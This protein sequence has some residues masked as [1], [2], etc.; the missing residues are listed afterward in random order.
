MSSIFFFYKL[1]FY[2]I[3]WIKIS[4]FISVF[5]LT[6]SASIYRSPEV[7]PF[8]VHE[9]ILFEEFKKKVKI[10]RNGLFNTTCCNTTN[11]IV[12]NVSHSLWPT[13]VYLIL[14]CFSL[15]SYLSTGIN[16]ELPY[17]F[18]STFISIWEASCLIWNL[19]R[20]QKF[21]QQRVVLFEGIFISM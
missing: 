8:A 7:E 12:P 14:L 13:D 16:R 21:C 4:L 1:W 3:N 9:I 18:I 5:V 15:F 6:T 2:L 10:S 17:T 20:I 19:N 11:H